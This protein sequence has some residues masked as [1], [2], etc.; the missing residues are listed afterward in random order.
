MENR[1]DEESPESKR[2]KD[3]ELPEPK[4]QKVDDVSDE[5]SLSLSLP[6]SSTTSQ[7]HHYPPSSMQTQSQFSQTFPQTPYLPSFFPHYLSS[8]S[9]SSS[10][11]STSLHHHSSSSQTQSQ[12]SQTFPQ[13]PYLP[14]FFPHYLWPSSFSSSSS[15]STSLYHH[16]SSSQRQSQFSQTFSQTPNLQLHLSLPQPNLPPSPPQPSP[17]PSPSPNPFPTSRTRRNPSRGPRKTKSATIP[18]PFPWATNKRAVVHSLNY[19]REN[20]ILTI[21]GA[22]KCKTCDGESG[23]DTVSFDLESK[24]AEV[25][26]Y[27]EMNKCRMH[28]RAPDVWDKPRL[29]SCR[30]CGN[31]VRP[32]VSEKKRSINWLFLLLGQMLGSCTLGQLKY[33]CK[34]NKF[35]RTG[36]KNRILYITYLG[37][38][39]QLDPMG[40]FDVM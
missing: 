26:R 21:T 2:Q 30:K 9:F 19:L 12:F 37:L 39:K 4:R 10:S 40:P 35:F 28:D 7:H 38:C 5:L 8:S 13:T 25:S 24:F 33:F 23:Y 29:P 14:S 16:S 27:V 11:S 22:V 31:S 17:S 3:E 34:H 32:V 36:A 18:E 1:D 15:S 20:Q 6:S